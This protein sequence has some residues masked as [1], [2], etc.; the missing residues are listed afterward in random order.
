M[1]KSTDLEISDYKISFVALIIQSFCIVV[2]N[3]Y[4]RYYKLTCESNAQKSFICLLYLR[5]CLLVIKLIV[6]IHLDCII[7]LQLVIQLYFVSNYF[8]KFAIEFVKHYW[9]Y[10]R[11]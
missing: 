1:H 9:S 5:F 6:L 11:V 3:I 7:N 4:S 10:K 2:S 8:I